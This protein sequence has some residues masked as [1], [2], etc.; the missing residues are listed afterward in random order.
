MQQHSRKNH[1]SPQ[2]EQRQRF[3]V[4]HMFSDTHI[5]TFTLQAGYPDQGIARHGRKRP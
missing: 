1:Q 4:D 2:R 5:P 3:H